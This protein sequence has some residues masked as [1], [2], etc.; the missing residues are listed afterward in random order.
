MKTERTHHVLR[1]IA[2]AAV[3]NADSNRKR[4]IR[5]ENFKILIFTFLKSFSK[6]MLRAPAYSQGLN[7]DVN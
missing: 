3:A 6:A 4:K 2:A 5:M 7:R 1:T